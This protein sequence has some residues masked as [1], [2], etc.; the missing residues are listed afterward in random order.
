MFKFKHRS[1]ITST[2]QNNGTNLVIKYKRN[3]IKS[4]DAIV[5]SNK[6]RHAKLS[7]DSSKS[8]MCA[9]DCENTSS[10]YR[11]RI[12]S[13]PIIIMHTDIESAHSLFKLNSY[14]DITLSVFDNDSCLRYNDSNTSF[15][16]F[17][18]YFNIKIRYPYQ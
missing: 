7:I 10:A 3:L 9:L 2:T 17:K 5:K 16:S 6:H 8:N 12:V 4:N 11:Y 15:N 14:D 1:L 13:L 18:S